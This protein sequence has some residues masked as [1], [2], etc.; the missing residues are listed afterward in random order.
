MPNQAQQQATQVA[1]DDWLG[2]LGSQDTLDWPERPAA[3]RMLDQRPAERRKVRDRVEHL[4][5]RP[6]TTEW[7]V[8]ELDYNRR[9]RRQRIRV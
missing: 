6:E 5:P 2:E 3:L 7:S 9:R 8:T 1:A 4:F